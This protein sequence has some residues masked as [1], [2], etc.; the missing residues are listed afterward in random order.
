[1]VASDV[2]VRTQASETFKPRIHGLVSTDK[3]G[4]STG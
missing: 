3:E 2:R 4:K 1:M